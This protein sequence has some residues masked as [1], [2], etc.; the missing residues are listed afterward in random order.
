MT[1]V[2]LEFY[3]TESETVVVTGKGVFLI[4]SPDMT[5]SYEELQAVPEGFEPV[6]GYDLEVPEEII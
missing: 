6:N 3:G 2:I 4:Q 5:A 1:E